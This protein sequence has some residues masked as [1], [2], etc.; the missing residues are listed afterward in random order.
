[1]RFLALG[2]V[3]ALSGCAAL[4]VN[5]NN[6]TP[7]QIKAVV[8][9]KNMNAQCGV[10]NTPY[11]K[12]IMVLVSIDKSVIPNGSVSVDDQCKI[13]FTNAPIPRAESA[14]KAAP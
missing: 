8:A 10:A 4:P 13:T 6:M 2:L 5:Y 1:M 14:P 12:G 7:E 3:L 11:G 9:D